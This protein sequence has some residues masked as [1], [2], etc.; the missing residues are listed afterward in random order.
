MTETQT[1]Q[2]LPVLP[3]KNTL[4]F[5]YLMLPLSVGRASSLAAVEAALASEEK[6]VALFVQRDSSVDNPTREDLHPIGVKA[7]IRKMS[8]PSPESMEILVL[9]IERIALLKL[10]D[11]E[12]FLRARIS[13]LPLPEDNAT[14]VEALHGA[15]VELAGRAV[16]LAQPNSSHEL[17]R[18]F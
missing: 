6:E 13:P 7:T 5:P 12:P 8:R 15:L 9:G 10:D 3:L 17:L 11:S 14:E 16:A 4:L 2:I 18:T 1:V